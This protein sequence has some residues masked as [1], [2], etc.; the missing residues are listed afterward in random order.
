MKPVLV[1]VGSGLAGSV[2]ALTLSLDFDVI[3]IE[4]TDSQANLFAVE[5]VPYDDGPAPASFGLGGTMKLWHNGLI[6]IEDSIFSRAW[7]YSKHVLKPFYE[8][9]WSLLA[10]DSPDLIFAEA[11]KLKKSLVS[12]GISEKLL[13]NTLY[14][15]QKRSNLWTK[16]EL[17]SAVTVIRGRAVEICYSDAEK[18]KITNIKV[19]VDDSF[20]DVFGDVFILSCGGLGTPLLLRSLKNKHPAKSL[21]FSGLYYEDHPAAYVATLKIMAPIYRLWNSSCN[22]SGFLRQPLKIIKDDLEISFQLRPALELRSKKEVKSILSRLRNNPLNIFLYPKLIFSLNDILEIASIKMGIRFPTNKYS[23]LMVAEQN[24][25]RKSFVMGCNPSKINV[26]W[27]IDSSYLR[28][29]SYAISSFIQ[30]LGVVED[31]YVY[32]KWSQ[33]LSSSCHHSGTA[34]MAKS[35]EEGVCDENAR[36]FGFDNLYICDGSIIPASGSANTGLTIAALA[37]KLSHF[38]KNL[39]VK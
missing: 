10:E 38:L 24:P 30:Q 22:L 21:K 15:P 31:Y 23:V 4:L 14:Y 3:V 16:F 37:L 2:L 35:S 34:R 8:G 33:N 6:E 32:P 25:N 27:R 9:A 28:T 1:I 20:L 26:D 19:Q 13:F 18:G 36:I 17:S 7:P 39:Y 5:G 11:A 12:M 29:L